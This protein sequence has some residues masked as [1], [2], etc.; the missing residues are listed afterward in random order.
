MPGTGVVDGRAAAI[1][2]EG[3]APHP[4]NNE[5]ATTSI[6]VADLGDPPPARVVEIPERI[7]PFMLQG[8][9]SPRKTSLQNG[10]IFRHGRE[11]TRARKRDPEL[12]DRPVPREAADSEPAS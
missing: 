6:N 10:L 9:W 11:L 8:D 7:S 1:V 4:A 2:G 5:T 12:D 3:D